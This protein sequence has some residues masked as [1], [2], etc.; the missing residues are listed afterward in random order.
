ME[1][2]K[3]TFVGWIDKLGGVNKYGMDIYVRTAKDELNEKYPQKL[4]FSVSTK[5]LEKID[6]TQHKKDAK[7]S[8]VFIPF[9]QQ[10]VSK[11]NKAYSINKMM[12]QSITLLEPAP[13]NE[14]G[15]EEEEMPF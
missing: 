11:M 4:M 9:L 7:V 12:L 13:V 8:I 10:G 1:P 15:A 14:N 6:D 3:Y 2:Q 5:N